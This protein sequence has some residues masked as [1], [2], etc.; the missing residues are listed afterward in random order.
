MPR[1]SDQTPAERFAEGEL[2]AGERAEADASASHLFSEQVALFEADEEELRRTLP[3]DEAESILSYRRDQQTTWETA[4]VATE[5]TAESA[6]SRQLG[7]ESLLTRFRS[8][9]DKLSVE[10]A[11]AYGSTTEQTL[12]IRM[13]SSGTIRGV[14]LASSPYIDRLGAIV[15]CCVASDVRALDI[16]RLV[17]NVLI[18]GSKAVLTA[19]LRVD[20][21][22]TEIVI[23]RGRLDPSYSAD[24]VSIPCASIELAYKESRDDNDG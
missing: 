23:L 13:Q 8:W 1:P 12:E 17:V 6:D 20:A 5:K 3:D 24:R 14:R 15:L 21:T 22:T 10:P 7:S 19:T 4:T 11:F 16:E 9:L 18:P 2:L